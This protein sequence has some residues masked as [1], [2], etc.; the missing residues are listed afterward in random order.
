MNQHPSP[1]LT[2]DADDARP[3]ALAPVVSSSSTSSLAS[4]AARKRCPEDFEFGRV[5]G[6]GSYSTVLYAREH[7]N[8]REY[9]VKMLD[10][11][12]IIKEKKTKYVAIEKDVL[13]KLAH[14]LIVKLYYT[15]Q[16]LHSLYFVLELAKDG[17]MLGYI[18]KL[19][20]FQLDAA[21][22]YIAEI[23]VAVMYLHSMGIVHRDLK[24]ENILLDE[25]MH[26]KITDFGTAKILDEP[27]SNSDT[28][29]FAAGST[30]ASASVSSSSP[31]PPPPAPSSSS[32]SQDAGSSKR[33]SFVGTAEYCSPELLNDRAASKSSDVWA[34]GCILYHLLA[35]RP[36]FKG[37]NEYQTFQKIIKLD[38]TFPDGFPPTARDLVSSILVLDTANRPSLAEIQKH[39][40][41]DGFDWTDIHTQQAPDLRPHLP[42]VSAHN[43]EELTSDLDA[44]TTTGTGQF[45]GDVPVLARDPFEDLLATNN[46]LMQQK[47]AAAASNPDLAKKLD[48]QDSHPLRH[49][50]T[51]TEVIV[52]D[53]TVYKR[54]GLFSKKRGL[55]LTDRP[56]LLFFD[57]NTLQPKSEIPWSDKLTVEL[58][59]SK[60]GAKNSS[61]CNSG[62]PTHL[63]VHTPKRTYYLEAKD[64]ARRW[65][66]AINLQRQGGSSATNT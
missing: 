14:P 50:V 55:V 21:R 24:P 16:D 57:H 52:M 35:G 53:G 6:E 49:L 4:Q 47:G 32:P 7:V 8:N 11:R 19:G 20:S 9:A 42:A 40:F 27:P 23:I 33:N 54:K 44:L 13:N 60:A 51:P 45:H 46:D 61:G 30:S 2:A 65:A 66:D 63:F 41:F 29:P 48:A 10:K 1:P 31:S 59:G 62:C 56:R 15:F 39:P 5:L 17:D 18:R 64:D 38:Y 28:D 37:V 43:V 22:F 58:K 25:N 26:I 12:H 34:I 36:P 3:A